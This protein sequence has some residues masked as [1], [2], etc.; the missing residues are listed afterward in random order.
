MSERNSNSIVDQYFSEINHF[1]VLSSEQE[2]QYAKRIRAGDERAFASLVEANLRFAV[3]VAKQYQNFGLPLSD[4]I[5]EAN[6]GLITAARRF[7]ETRG[8]KF[9]S[10]AVWWVRQAI[11]KALADQ[12]R[13]VR[14]PLN[15]VGELVR[16]SKIHD[17]L[18]QE[19]GRPPELEEIA[20]KMGIKGDGL[21]EL[22]MS[23]QHP[24]SLD[25]PLDS[26]DGEGDTYGDRIVYQDQAGTAKIFGDNGRY[27]P[28]GYT[29][30]P[31]KAL[32]ITELEEAVGRAVGTLIESEARVL[33]MYFGFD[34]CKP[35]TLEEIG[36]YVGRTRERVRQIKEKALQK[37]RHPS[38]SG[39]LEE[40]YQE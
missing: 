14:L 12:S 3:S 1:P 11:L 19:L 7:D 31:E 23:N 9:I 10:Y 26:S 17:R 2:A 13:T 8:Y 5:N 27:S 24:I 35:M 36:V 33:R 40:F 30:V 38:H 32:V 39:V 6:Y 16:I 15:R 22:V 37:L 20:V 28:D 34:G 21:A 25:A 4:L 18:E 29:T